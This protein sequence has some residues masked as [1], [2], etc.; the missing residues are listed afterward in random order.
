MP[1]LPL[2]GFGTMLVDHTGVSSF[3]CLLEIHLNQT[4]HLLQLPLHFNRLHHHCLLT[5]SFA[6][7]GLF[8]YIQWTSLSFH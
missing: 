4:H 3:L 5:S 8:H 6:C 2:L 7:P 1:V